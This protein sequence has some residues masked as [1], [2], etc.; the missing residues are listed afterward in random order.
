MATRPGTLLTYI[1]VPLQPDRMKKRV[2]GVKIDDISL[3]Q[4]V[5]KV[6]FWMT[7]RSGYPKI[8][9]TPG[10]EFLVTA[11]GDRQ[12]RE[13]L[14]SFDLSL[15]DGFGLHLAGMKNRVP[16]VRLLLDL[17]KLSAEKNYTV[18]LFG[19]RK[20]IA[21]ATASELIK[22][23]PNI[24]ITFTADGAQADQ[25]FKTPINKDQ[26]ANIKVGILFVALG[27]PKQEKFLYRLKKD[28]LSKG[29]PLIDF[30]VGIGV[31]GAFDYLSGYK[32]WP[33]RALQRLGLEW[34]WRALTNPNR[35]KH[36]KRLL[37]ATIVFPLS[38]LKERLFPSS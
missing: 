35:P 34:L 5:D 27:H 30:R 29:S 1:G 22:R 21:K 7:E 6:S 17:C 33:P 32:P 14:N 10:P 9:A 18:G 37:S 4:V 24:K 20:G 2:L 12:F 31:G 11:Q 13:V 16:G 36:I 38:L 25:I 15:P 8:I 3:K 19:G 26:S 28:D 23:Y